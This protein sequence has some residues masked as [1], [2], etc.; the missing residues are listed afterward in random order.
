MDPWHYI[1]MK[2]TGNITTRLRLDL[3]SVDLSKLRN[4]VY[5]KLQ[6]TPYCF[7]VL[8]GGC[9]SFRNTSIKI[10]YKENLQVTAEEM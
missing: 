6:T 2:C 3:S 9:L 4:I 5:F 7:T 1:K 8:Y 10:F